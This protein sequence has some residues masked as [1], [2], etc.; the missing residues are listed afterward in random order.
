MMDC[1]HAETRMSGIWAKIIRGTAGCATSK[2]TLRIC[3]VLTGNFPSSLIHALPITPFDG[4]DC[5]I[6]SFSSS[7]ILDS[8]V[9][10][11]TVGLNNN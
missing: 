11:G 8:S 4:L 7:L 5:T 3:Y 1:S 2:I 6:L 9:T 10:L